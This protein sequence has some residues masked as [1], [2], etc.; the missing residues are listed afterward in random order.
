MTCITYMGQLNGRIGRLGNY[1]NAGQGEIS[2]A[3]HCNVLLLGRCATRTLRLG[4]S[5]RQRVELRVALEDPREVSVPT[6]FAN[7]VAISQ[8]GTE[9]QFEFVAID[10]NSIATKLTEVTENDSAGPAEIVGKTVAK[11]VVP[12][13]VFVQLEG[14]LQGIFQRVKNEFTP[15]EDEAA[16]EH[17]SAV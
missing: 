16:D 4:D 17:S 13:H 1:R 10:L 15:P 3:G 14:H 2:L 6:L 9:V 8:A 5:M 12:L 11:V 7:H